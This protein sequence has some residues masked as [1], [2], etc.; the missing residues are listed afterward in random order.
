MGFFD[1]VKSIKNMVTGGGATVTIGDFKPV[2]GEPFSI[3]ITAEIGD[4]DVKIDKV[5]LLVEGNETVRIDNFRFTDGEGDSYYKDIHTTENTFR[6]EME[7]AESQTLEANETYTWEVELELQDVLPTYH[8]PNAEHSWR[9][10]AA[11]DAFGNDPDSGWV[12][13]ELE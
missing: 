7:V 1:K 11:L 8:G 6:D 12:M 13:F 2:W 4:A 5:Y 3:S 10:Q 9:L